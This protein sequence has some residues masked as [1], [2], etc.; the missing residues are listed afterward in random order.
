MGL[1]AIDKAHTHSTTE[2]PDCRPG[3]WA[4]HMIYVVWSDIISVEGAT[5]VKGAQFTQHNH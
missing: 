3:V 4:Q 2:G 5:T 1:L